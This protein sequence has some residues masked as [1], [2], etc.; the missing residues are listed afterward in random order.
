MG[1]TVRVRLLAA[2][3]NFDLASLLNRLL[4]S[5]RYRVCLD[6]S[7]VSRLGT[8]E[9]RVLGSFAEQFER[10]GGF[11]I[12]EN[13]SP[14]LAA[15]VREFGLTDLMPVVPETQSAHNTSRFAS[16]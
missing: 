9:F 4:A 16:G 7:R 3:D 15:L 14:N 1:N 8:V 10:R 13:V 2:V 12:L 6:V 5:K 11:L